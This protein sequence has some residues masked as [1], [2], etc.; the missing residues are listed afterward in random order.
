MKV[1][2]VYTILNTI[3]KEILGE[4]VIVAEDLSNIVDVGVAFENMNNGYDNYVKSLIDH[5]GKV[6]FVDRVYAGRMPSVIMDGWEYGSILE[7]IRMDLPEARENETWSLTDGTS[8]DPNVFRKPVISAKFFNDRV[9]FEVQISI[10][11]KQVKSAFSSATQMNGLMSMIYTQVE[12]SLTIKTDALIGRVIN[13]AIGETLYSEFP[14]GTYAGVSGVRAVNLLKLYN[15]T[16]PEGETEVTASEA[17]F[18]PAFIRFASYTIKNYVSRLRTMSRLFNIGGTNKFT[19]ADKL[20]LVMLEQFQSAA[21][22]YLYDGLNQFKDSSLRF[23]ANAETV[24]Y[25]QGSGKTFDFAD[26]SKI[27][28]KTPSNH[29]ITASGIIAVMFDRDAVGVANLDKYTDSIYNPVASFWN[30]WHKVDMGLFYDSD[31][32]FV[33]FYIA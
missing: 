4:T 25:W 13:A 5:I 20:H 14:T 26:T 6:V 18:D 21:E 3:T 15:D 23:P 2:Q 9:T 31:E 7:K 27:M 11:K 29:D 19:P 33:V 10:T 8:Y 28:I 12:N 1:E 32:N 24:P 16:L 17:I 22:V 30:E